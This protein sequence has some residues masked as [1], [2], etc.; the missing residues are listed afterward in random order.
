MLLFLTIILVT[1]FLSSHKVDLKETLFVMFASV[2]WLLACA[3]VIVL[4]ILI[5]VKPR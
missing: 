5:N 4:F 1:K 3:S 2:M